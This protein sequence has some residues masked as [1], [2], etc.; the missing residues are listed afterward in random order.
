MGVYALGLA[1][2]GALVFTL[3][4]SLRSWRQDLLPFLKA[5]EHGVAQGRSRMADVLVVVQLAFCVLLLAARVW[6][7]D[8]SASSIPPNSA[9]PRTID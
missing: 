4:P 5:G 1:I 2:C 8:P 9:I 3:A 7:R 6:P